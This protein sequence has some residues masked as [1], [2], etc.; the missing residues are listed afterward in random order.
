MITEEFFIP[1]PNGKSLIGLPR[2]FE[3][4]AA[5]IVR[6]YPPSAHERAEALL[7]LSD[8]LDGKVSAAEKRELLQLSEDLEKKDH[9]Q[10]T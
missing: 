5:F 7:S 6:V 9:P 1:G 3:K 2:F 8:W 10:W 4:P